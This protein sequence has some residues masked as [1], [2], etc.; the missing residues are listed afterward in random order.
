MV[1]VLGAARLF[2]EVG[3]SESFPALAKNLSQGLSLP[4]SL[5]P[6]RV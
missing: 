5:S 4:L 3:A 6:L 1:K 2:G